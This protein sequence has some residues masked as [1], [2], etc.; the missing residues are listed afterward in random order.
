MYEGGG[1]QGLAGRQL[2]QAGAGQV[3]QILVYQ[4]QQIIRGRRIT[5]YDSLKHLSDRFPVIN[6][7][8][9]L[10][11]ALPRAYTAPTRASPIHG[12][13]RLVYAI[14]RNRSIRRLSY[15]V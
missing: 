6:R 5:G 8:A 1:L 12:H 15:R 2:S 3:P 4:R 9:V 11:H 13:K 14:G 7:H 10:W